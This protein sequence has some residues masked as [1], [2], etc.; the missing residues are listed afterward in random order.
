MVAFFVLLTA[1]SPPAIG[2]G[3]E[4][5][6]VVRCAREL[7]RAI[8]GKNPQNRPVDLV[9]RMAN[10]PRGEHDTFLIL[11]DT[12]FSHLKNRPTARL[13]LPSSGDEVRLL[14]Y[15]RGTPN[16]NNYAILTNYQVL[17]H[18]PAVPPTPIEIA[19]LKSEAFL[20]RVVA[21]RGHVVDVFRDDVDPNIVF[22]ILSDGR[23][24]LHA[25]LPITED[26]LRKSASLP[27]AYVRISGNSYSN[28]QTG[29]R[30]Y[31]GVGVS[32][33]DFDAVEVLRPAPA[34]RFDV[35]SI[36]ERLA[37]RDGG[38]AIT[39][40][41]RGRVLAAWNGNSALLR[42][43]N[44]DVSRI[45]VK[46]G[47]LPPPGAVIEA[48]G[49]PETDLYCRNLSYAEWRASDLTL[50]AEPPAEGVSADY[51]LFNPKGE[52]AIKAQYHG[53]TV[54]LRGLVRS[55]SQTTSSELM[56]NVECD[57][58]IIPVRVRTA[59]ASGLAI[60]CTAEVTGTCVMDIENC[61]S[62]IHV[63]RINGFFIVLS[64]PRD[65][66]ILA[67][68]PW[69]TLR[70]L[71]IVVAALAALLVYLLLRSGLLKKLSRLKL[72]ERMRL[73]VELHD[74][75][76]QNLTGI[77]FEIN[78]VEQLVQTD[79]NAAIR[80]LN[81]ASRTLES[82]RDDLRHCIWD[83]RNHTLEE[84]DLSTAIRRTLE[85]HL[86][87]TVLSVR[88]NIPR[89]ILSDN[90]A[91][92][93][94]RIIRELVLNAIRHG[95]ASTVRIAGA[96]EKD[97]LLF[98]VTDNGEGFDPSDC[99]G[100]RTGHFGMQGVRERIREFG[101]TADWKSTPGHGT[102]ATLSLDLRIMKGNRS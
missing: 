102:R 24:A 36:G 1:L 85:P 76:A 32:I 82:C 4:T 16:R 35:P 95:H 27:G 2:E 77:S 50:P 52:P 45:Q 23:D 11:D 67:H 75:I 30:K 8:Y 74:T 33:D 37:V 42:G 7:S 69:W 92:A 59:A 58:R 100:I 101:G 70:R 54:R 44:G 29:I 22:I 71:M 55:I 19:D 68:P 20:D 98:S 25:T 46:E 66:R 49:I 3:A 48:V 84:G 86:G 94:L 90:A 47:N 96:R 91:H 53:R 12:G 72:A 78:A 61:S 40:K 80:H 38:D 56:L 64:D 21:I 83:L 57:R 9:A 14:G 97:R 99:P 51:L 65:I 43:E 6:E 41:I 15:V 31:A 89:Q 63:P 26:V 93:L 73:A 17:A 10:S 60:G 81:T 39:R 87:G 62:L 34:D 79:M 28:R 13:A 5:D 18:G 88:F